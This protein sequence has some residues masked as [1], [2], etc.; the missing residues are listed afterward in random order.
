MSFSG[1]KHCEMGMHIRKMD[2]QTRVFPGVY[3][4]ADHLRPEPSPF[5]LPKFF[6]TKNIYT[7]LPPRCRGLYTSKKAKLMEVKSLNNY[8]LIRPHF[9]A[10]IRYLIKMRR[11]TMTRL[12]HL[13]N[14]NTTN[15]RTILSYM[16]QSNNTMSKKL[17][18]QC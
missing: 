4:Y 1:Q 14:L 2:R 13:Q 15:Q 18:K 8:S 17:L 3:P 11:A 12:P 16:P 10:L 5:P 6:H 7:S 9:N